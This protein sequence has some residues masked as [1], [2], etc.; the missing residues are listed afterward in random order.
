M[1]AI[2]D[3]GSTKTHVVCLDNGEIVADIRFDGINPYYQSK[4]EIID[5]LSNNIKSISNQITNFYF[6]GAGCSFPEK[7]H[8]VWDSVNTVCGNSEIEIESDLMGAAKALFGNGNGIAC[9]L[10]TGSNSCQYEQG[11]IIKNVSPLGYVLGDEGSGAVLGKLFVSD[12]LKGILEKHIIESFYNASGL[13]AE[14][15]MDSVY[16]KPLPNRFLASLVPYIVNLKHHQQVELIIEKNFQLF[17]ERNISQYDKYRDLEISFIGSI[18]LQFK[19]EL[20][21][22]AKKFGC[23]IGKIEKDPIDGLIEFYKHCL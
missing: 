7:K 16:K 11:E 4:E 10:G 9:I 15:I 20:N 17:F 14:S 23:K 12:C 5:L 1:I 19:E 18:G 6:F 22:A 2:A 13:S 8:I 21:N 3:S